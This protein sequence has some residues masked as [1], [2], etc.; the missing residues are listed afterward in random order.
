MARGAE[1]AGQTCRPGLQVL[2]IQ[3]NLDT[4]LVL[5]DRLAQETGRDGSASA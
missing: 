2:D 3:A 4:L 5:Y 1:E